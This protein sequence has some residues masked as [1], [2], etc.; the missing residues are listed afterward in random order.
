M[1][2]HQNLFSWALASCLGICYL[3]ASGLPAYAGKNLSYDSYQESSKTF[4]SSSPKASGFAIS[5]GAKALSNTHHNRNDSYIQPALFNRPPR[6]PPT[7]PP[8]RRS[9]S[10]PPR[11]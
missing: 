2:Y 6:R 3:I 4:S 11:R 8:P 10:R 9:P 5:L 1:N 7:A